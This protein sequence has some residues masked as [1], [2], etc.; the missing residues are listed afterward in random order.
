MEEKTKTFEEETKDITGHIADFI[1]TYFNL[2]T[3][4][5]AQKSVHFVSSIVN[6]AILVL[7]GFL[8]IFFV[9]L[10]L[11]WWLGTIIN[12]R[13]GGFF[14]VGGVYLLCIVLFIA[15]KKNTI[16]PFLRNFI[17]RMIYE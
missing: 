14:I 2:V 8:V 16:L 7:L 4:K 12:N 3:V 1:E 13:A 10:G 9:G 5:V 17:T 11:A 15:M 6:F